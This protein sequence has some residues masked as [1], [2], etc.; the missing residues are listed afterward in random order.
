MIKRIKHLAK[1]L[2]RHKT[3]ILD[4]DFTRFVIR[5][6]CHGRGVE[7]GPGPIPYTRDAVLVDKFTVDPN[8]GK[9]FRVDRVCDGVRLPFGDG[10]FDYLVSSNMIEH[11]PDTIGALAE[12]RRVVR[13]GGRI[14]LR[15]P[16]K[17]RTFDRDRPLTTLAHHIADARRMVDE[18]DTTH[19]AEWQYLV[20]LHPEWPWVAQAHGDWGYMARNGLV[21]YHVWTCDSFLPLVR[22][23]G[24]RVLLAIAAPPAD[25][26]SFIVVAE[27]P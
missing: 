9:P 16:H 15:A 22:H 8:T 4:C 1:W 21:H 20:A 18:T 10:S 6:Y 5:Q 3:V 13:S 24:L 23:V 14:M 7:I 2:V 27:V 17:D 26:I 11:M 25:D 19:R 12:W